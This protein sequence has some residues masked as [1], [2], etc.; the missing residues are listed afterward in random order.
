MDCTNG[1][2]ESGKK[3]GCLLHQQLEEVLSPEG[4]EVAFDGLE[5]EL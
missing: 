2:I 4:I 5:I 1:K 3:G